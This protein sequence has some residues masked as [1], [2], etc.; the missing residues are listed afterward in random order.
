MHTRVLLVWVGFVIRKVPRRSRR[1]APCR[2]PGRLCVG[3]EMQERGEG[4]AQMELGLSQE[5]IMVDFG[6]AGRS[7][8]HGAWR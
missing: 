5:E 4:W 8:R 7:S 6:G 2:Q 3:K 1:L